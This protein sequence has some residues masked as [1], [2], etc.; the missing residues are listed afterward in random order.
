[1]ILNAAMS[2][3]GKIATFA[4]DSR[5]SSTSDIKRVHGLRASVDAIMVGLRTLLVDDPKLTVRSMASRRR[6]PYR[7]IVDSRARSPLTS[8]VVRTAREAP[9]IIATTAAAPSKRIEML[10]KK[11]VTIL[12][13]GKGPRVSLR[14]LLK[15]LKTLRIRRIMLEG[16]GA[17]NWSMLH[18]DLVDEI[19]VA[20]TPKIIGGVNAISLVEGKGNALVKEGTNLKLVSIARYGPD[21][22]VRYKV[23]NRTSSVKS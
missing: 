6:L 7:I 5:L 1:M 15:R 18:D 9:T 12:T 23:L 4:G 14:L 10:Q 20:I 16:G 21:L 19:S 11:G 13:C 8:Y 17:L 2:L 22:V 3:D